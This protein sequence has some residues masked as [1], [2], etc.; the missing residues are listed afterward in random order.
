MN[1]WA[2]DVVVDGAMAAPV[3]NPRDKIQ[4]RWI[5][6]VEG[7]DTLAQQWHNKAQQAQQGTTN[8][9]QSRRC[10]ATRANFFLARLQGPHPSDDKDKIMDET[11]KKQ[12]VKAQWAL[13]FKALNGSASTDDGDNN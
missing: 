2:I 6:A 7:Q 1:S 9:Y 10:C 12:R 8:A 4:S 13:L 3:S 11:H 5:P